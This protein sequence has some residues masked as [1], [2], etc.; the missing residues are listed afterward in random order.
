M[1]VRVCF[2]PFIKW[3]FFGHI[4]D[5]I[6]INKYGSLSFK[7]LL[8]QQMLTVFKLTV[9]K[10]SRKEIDSRLIWYPCVEKYISYDANIFN[11]DRICVKYMACTIKEN[12]NDIF[13]TL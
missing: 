3:V 12:G 11:V 6:V 5:K 10:T 1:F 2:K 9:F 13:V 4:F 8:I 7:L